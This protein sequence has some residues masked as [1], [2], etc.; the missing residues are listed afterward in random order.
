PERMNSPLPGGEGVPLPALLPAGAGRVRGHFQGEKAPDRLTSQSSS[1][2]PRSSIAV[3]SNSTPQ[4][5]FTAEAGGE[6]LPSA[7]GRATRTMWRFGLRFGCTARGGPQGQRETRGDAKLSP[8][9]MVRER[10]KPLTR[11]ATAGES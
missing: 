3:Q 2:A 1:A 11:P 5:D 6:P 9:K 10:K 4:P 7:S 8:D